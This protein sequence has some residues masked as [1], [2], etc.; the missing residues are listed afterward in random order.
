MTTHEHAAPPKSPSGPGDGGNRRT[1]PDPSSVLPWGVRVGA[2]AAW[3]LV[4]LAAALWILARAV[5]TVQLVAL[6]FVVALFA[7]ALLRPAVC[8]LERAGLHRALATALVIVA[9]FAVVT[10]IGWFVVWQVVDHSDEVAG[11]LQEGIHQ[12][13]TWALNSPLHVTDQQVEQ[14]AHSLSDAVGTNASKLAATGLQGATFAAEFLTGVLLTAFSTLF[15]VYD[16]PRVW[17]WVLGLVPGAGRPAVAA[18]APHAW[19]TLTAYV[20]GTVAVAFIDGL[21]IG[22]GLY[23]LDVPLAVPLAALVFV[24]AFVPLAGAVASGALAVLVALVTCG[25]VTALAVLLVVLAVQQL[26]GH[27]L[28]PFILGRAVRVHPLAVILS[29]AAGGLAAGVGGAVIAVPLVA[30]A[31]TMVGRLREAAGAEATSVSTG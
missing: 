16:G 8:R 29:V 17:R 13:R 27:V 10:L 14:A 21:F 26:E 31:N 20:R 19:R 22:L 23:L 30:V 9:G 7:T 18:A 4:V 25:P 11:R 12:L 2:E 24:C 3:R 15:L 1:A 6:S 28:Q 5:A